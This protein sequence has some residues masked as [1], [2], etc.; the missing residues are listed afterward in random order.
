M[1]NLI[2]AF[3]PHQARETII[4]MLKTQIEERREAAREIRQTIDASRRAVEQAHAD[5][6][7]AVEDAPPLASAASS[8]LSGAVDDAGDVKM[9]DAES[10][11]DTAS[12]SEGSE[13]S[14]LTPAQLEQAEVRVFVGLLCFDGGVLTDVWCR[15]G[16]CRRRRRRSGCR[17][18]SSPR[19]RRPWGERAWSG[20][21][22]RATSSRRGDAWQ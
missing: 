10:A 5:M 19:W 4:Q 9:E 18:S 11:A 14:A 6:L 12:V 16:L 17:S 7:G 1:H 3:R 13:V 8:P 22:R 20:G 2:N 15:G 21:S